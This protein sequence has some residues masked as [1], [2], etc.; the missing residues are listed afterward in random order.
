MAYFANGTEGEWYEYHICARCVHNGHGTDTMCAVW[1]IHLDQNYDQHNNPEIKAVLDE[2][3]PPASD[4]YNGLCSM[5]H[6][7]RTEWSDHGENYK[8]W[9]AER[10]RSK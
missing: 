7:S 4:G 2:L 6:P 3:I 9:L 10:G 5:F 1:A 8:K